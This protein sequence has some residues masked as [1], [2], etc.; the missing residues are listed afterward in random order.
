MSF[1]CSTLY[2]MLLSSINPYLIHWRLETWFSLCLNP[3]CCQFPGKYKIHT[4][5]RAQPQYSYHL[6][7]W[8]FTHSIQ[9]LTCRIF[10]SFFL[11][12]HL[13]LFQM[14]NLNYFE[15]TFLSTFQF[16]DLNSGPLHQRD[17]DFNFLLAYLAYL[18]LLFLNF[19]YELILTILSCFFHF[20]F[21]S[22][23]SFL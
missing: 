15:D 4:E 6:N 5:L 22:P 14:K 12:N 18:E 20:L 11:G 16:Q 10:L 3:T 21:L 17:T 13:K 9:L 1:I 23:Q 2:S 7:P 19:I 8:N